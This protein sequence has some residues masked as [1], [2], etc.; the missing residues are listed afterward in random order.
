VLLYCTQNV[1]AEQEEDLEEEVI[2]KEEL[3]STHA[4]SA[5]AAP[6]KGPGRKPKGRLKKAKAKKPINITGLDFLHTQTLLSTSPQGTLL[7]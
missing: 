2:G 3:D 5:P 6:A 4:W 1:T 7:T